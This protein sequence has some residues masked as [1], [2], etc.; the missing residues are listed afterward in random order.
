M[1]KESTPRI[2]LTPDVHQKEEKRAASE[3]NVQKEYGTSVPVK[4]PVEEDMQKRG[5]ES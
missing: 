5:K 1:D 2:V 3:K 4:S